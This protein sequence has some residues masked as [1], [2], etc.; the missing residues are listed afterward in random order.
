MIKTSIASALVLFCTSVSAQVAPESALQVQHPERT[1]FTDIVDNEGTLIAVGKHGTIVTSD[2]GKHWQQAQV[3]VQ[4]LLTA[5]TSLSADKS[6]A[7]GHDSSILFSSDKGQTWQ[8]QQFLPQQQKPC[9]DIEFI[10]PNVGFAIGAYGMFYQTE[11]GGKTWHK[12]FIDDFVHPDD[13]DYLRELK[14]DDPQ[15]YEE[16][17]QFILP[18]FNRLL[19]QQQQLFLVGEM[20]L[21]AQSLDMGKSW[22]RLDEFYPGSFF[23]VASYDDEEIIVAGLRGNAFIANIDNLEFR[24][25]KT[26]AKAT[27]NSLVNFENKTYMLANSGYLFGYEKGEVD[28]SQLSSGHAILSAVTFKN[29]LVLATE[30][31]LK[32]W[33]AKK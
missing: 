5:V 6:W 16:E 11:D 22:Q 2:D 32:T 21:V 9:L 15:A 10:D 3:P 20:G 33:E 14:E 23:S 30:K 28:S 29:K 26:P 25:I 13:K 12:R 19:T 7:C 27:I 1:L 4:S 8:I 17:T 24:K 31:G 18:H